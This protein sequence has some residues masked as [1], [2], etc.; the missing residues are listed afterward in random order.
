LKRRLLITLAL[1]IPLLA[2]A[3]ACGGDETPAPTTSTPATTNTPATTATSTPTAAET[4]TATATTTAAP[5]E[6]EPPT[7]TA[8][9]TQTAEPTEPPVTGPAG[10]DV[11]GGSVESD[12]TSVTVA[13]ATLPVP[14]FV[15]IH[16]DEGGSPGPVIGVSELLAA[17]LSTDITITLDE[18]LTASGTVFPMV[19]VDANG[20][21]VYEFP[22]VDVPGVTDTGEVAVVALEVEVAS[23]TAEPTD[24]AEPTGTEDPEPTGTSEPV[25]TQ[26]PDPDAVQRAHDVLFGPEVLGEEWEI[27]GEDD[28]SDSLSAGFESNVQACQD[29]NAIFLDAE[30]RAA[31][32]RI[33]R[34][35]RDMEGA[36]D[37]TNFFGTP[38]IEQEV[39][40]FENESVPAEILD[41]Y[42]EALEGDTFET[43]FRESILADATEDT[44]ST[45][46]RL[47]PSV[48]APNDGAALAFKLSFTF[49]DPLTMAPTTLDL[50]FEAV[51]WVEG[52]AGVTLSY[53]GGSQMPDVVATSV[54]ALAG[55][56]D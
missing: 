8:E 14:G 47:E 2:L 20:N 28:F 26:E 45:V 36:D 54:E 52:D 10:L 32:A 44:T 21:G 23:A 19:H 38:N 13:S 27:T 37:P 3:A 33:G 18:P 31:A 51:L 43:C 48:E 46:E 30:R 55:N 25:E 49:P 50:V 11:G 16:S 4:T 56:L 9:P 12:G 5:T 22:G 41:L 29:L 40:I 42:K 1:A 24:T 15:A 17:G 6:T 7:E 34:A 35:Q 53:S 39:S